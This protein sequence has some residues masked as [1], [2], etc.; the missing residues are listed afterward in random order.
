MTRDELLP[1]EQW[2]ETLPKCLVAAGALLTDP[3]GRVLIVK[4]NYRDHWLFVGGMLDEGETPER[5]C[6][7]E[8]R[9]E[10]GL[11]RQPGR[12]LLVDWT[13]PSSHRPLP[14]I[15]FIFDGGVVAPDQVRLGED[16]LDEH[17]FLPSEQAMTLLSVNGRK[18]LTAALEA[19][20]SGTML[21]QSEEG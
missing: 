2:V 7:R 9:E 21:Y 19:K 8:V 11:D 3:D 17:R 14:L 10:I 18:Q 16:E 4:P 1:P 15:E 12:L 5:A 13:P 20:R 6:R